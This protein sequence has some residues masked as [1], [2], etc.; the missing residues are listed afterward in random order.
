MDKRFA[1][2]LGGLIIIVVVLLIIFG[3]SSKVSGTPTNHVEGSPSTGVKLVEYGD[4]QCP[5]CGDFYQ[6]IKDVAQ[7]YS[8]LIQFQFINF[9]LTSIHPNTF[10][11]S[12]AAEAAAMQGKFWQM[13][14]KLYEQNQA[15][16]LNQTPTWI[17]ASDPMPFFNQYAKELGLNMNQFQNDFKSSKVNDEINA[18]KNKGEKLQVDATPTFYL[19]GNKLDLKQMSDA[20]GQPSLDAISKL[21][22]QAIQSKT[23]KPVDKSQLVSVTAP[24]NQQTT[25]VEQSHAKQ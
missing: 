20:S 8:K 22:D 18:D 24:A 11:A 17:P 1:A 9:P 2:I 13:H 5:G 19:D 6:T 12:R 23:G 4:Y 3:G 7:K 25:P 16:Y 21:I 10:A 15:Y 14:D